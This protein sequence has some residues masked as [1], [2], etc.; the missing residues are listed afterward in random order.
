MMSNLC[1]LAVLVPTCVLDMEGGVPYQIRS[2]FQVAR[3]GPSN[4][5]ATL[6]FFS[7]NTATFKL[8]DWAKTAQARAIYFE[9]KH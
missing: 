4:Q 7:N 1:G 3:A 5:S 9:C 8:R 2:E 6:P